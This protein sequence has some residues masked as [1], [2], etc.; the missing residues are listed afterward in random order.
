MPQTEIATV[1]DHPP[2]D[3]LSVAA[4]CFEERG[5]DATSIDEVARGVGATKGRV[6]HHFRSK[7]DL[8]AAVFRSGMAMLSEAVEPILERDYAPVEKLRRLASAHTRTILSTK[9]F[10]RVV[11]EGVEMHL[12]G[13]TTPGQREALDALARARNT[14]GEVF[15]PVMEA[16]RRDGMLDYP[17]P[18]VAL[19]LFLMTLN[20]PVIWYSPREDETE[21]DRERLVAQTVD[22]A[23][24]GLGER[25]AMAA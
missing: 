21:A 19:Q 9:A 22:F 13:A 8:F 1:I 17:N 25:K 15:R 24:A 11:W 5:Y 18:S 12:R 16:A 14:Y 3:I 4:R 2:A 20:S 7:A 10:Q 6:Y 23:M